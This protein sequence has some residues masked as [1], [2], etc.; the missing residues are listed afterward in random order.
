M[1]WEKRVAAASTLDALFSELTTPLW[2][3]AREV[4]QRVARLAA[5]W[6]ALSPGSGA[7]GEAAAVPP[8]IED[9]AALEEIG[10][11]LRR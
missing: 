4:P 3:A 5:L 11:V 6:P 9:P 2:D 8:T 10:A 7:D 1:A